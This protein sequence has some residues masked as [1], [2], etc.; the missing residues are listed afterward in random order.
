MLKVDMSVD[1]GGRPLAELQRLME[2]RTRQLKETPRDATI[3]TAITVLR[4]L[5]PLVRKAK[6]APKAGTHFTIKDTGWVGG[7]RSKGDAGKMARFFKGAAKG[8]NLD[9]TKYMERCVRTSG[10]RGQIIPFIHPLWLVG[11][12]AFEK[13]RVVHIYRVEPRHRDLMKWEKNR[14]HGCWF[15]AAYT[16]GVAEKAAKRMMAKYLKKYSGLAR[17]TLT[18]AMRH[19]STKGV[20]ND[21]VSADARKIAEGNLRVRSFGGASE[22]TVLIEDD[23]AYAAQ[24][25]KRPDAVDYAMAKAANSMA[26]MLRRR[27]RGLLDPSIETPFPEIAQSRRGA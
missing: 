10:R 3:A 21:R 19:I 23:L 5:R 6:T 11:P 15:I 7:W 26:G 4:S 2:K 8:L 9:S 17:F 24:A 14:H 16:Q 22:W 20:P 13:G 27:S 25:F 1:W 18:Q 12:G